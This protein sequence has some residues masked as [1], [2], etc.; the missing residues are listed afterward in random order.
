MTPP[1]TR[2]KAIRSSPGAD[3]RRRDFA[4]HSSPISICKDFIKEIIKSAEDQRDAACQ[5][6]RYRR[7]ITST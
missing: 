7:P 6:G 4:K 1:V 5:A 2:S 3:C